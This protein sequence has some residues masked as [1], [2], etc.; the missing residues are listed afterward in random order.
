MITWPA[1][2]W[3]DQPSYQSYHLQN[4]ILIY[5]SYQKDPYCILLLSVMPADAAQKKMLKFGWLGAEIWEFYSKKYFRQDIKLVELSLNWFWKDLEPGLAVTLCDYLIIDKMTTAIP[6]IPGFK[7]VLN[8]LRCV[9]TMRL[10]MP[11]AKLIC[12]HMPLIRNI[13]AASQWEM[14]GCRSRSKRANRKV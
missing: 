7:P 12:W 6:S 14:L 10:A 5:W 1:Y 2:C 11:L 3:Q 8:P 4:W 13:S 9:H